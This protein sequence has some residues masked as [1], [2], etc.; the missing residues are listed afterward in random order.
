MADQK[1]RDRSDEAANSVARSVEHETAVKSCMM[2][3]TEVGLKNFVLTGL[4]STAV[5]AAA[6]YASPIFRARL[7]PSGKTAL[8][9]SPALF[10]GFCS[11]EQAMTECTRRR[12]WS[13]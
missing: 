10:W 4:V 12:K 9:F 11:S 3:A 7:G 6:T 8:A 2:E 5:V 13:S 1:E